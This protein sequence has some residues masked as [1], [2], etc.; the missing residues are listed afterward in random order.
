[1]YRM[2]YRDFIDRHKETKADLT[3]SVTPVTEEDASSYGLLKTDS[4]GKIVEFSE[5]P[6]GEQLHAMRVDTTAFGLTE[7]E[8]KEKPYLASMG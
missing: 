5:K 1:L 6:R 8:A 2:D 3:V 7:A 4:T